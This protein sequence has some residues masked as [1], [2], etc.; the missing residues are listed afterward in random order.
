MDET[1]QSGRTAI[2]RGGRVSAPVRWLTAQ[3][4]LSGSVLHH[5]CGHAKWD[6][7]A[8]RTQADVVEYDPNWC[9]D[10]TALERTYDVLVSSYVLN[11]L[12]PQER[13][14]CL[15]QMTT[16]APRALIAVRADRHGMT[17]TQEADGV[18]T[19]RQTFQRAYTADEL[20]DELADFFST[21]DIV[22]ADG[23]FVIADCSNLT[24]QE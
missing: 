20:R 4:P 1:K 6:T 5:G 23:R 7:E 9:P 19:S 13:R 14:E 22:Y 16:L 8:L 17:G 3:C 10:A 2:F 12:P 15:G 18:R 24:P 21:V 11:V